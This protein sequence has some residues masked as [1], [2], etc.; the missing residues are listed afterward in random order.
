MLAINISLRWS[1]KHHVATVPGLHIIAGETPRSHLQLAGI[2]GPVKQRLSLSRAA[3]QLA[4]GTVLLKLCNVSL[5][6]APTF[7]LPLIVDRAAAEVVAAIPLE[8]TARILF[9]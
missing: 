2:V 5:C 7:D 8:P 1:E 3:I 9:V 4:M 6:C